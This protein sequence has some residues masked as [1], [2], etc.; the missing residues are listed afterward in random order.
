MLA[1]LLRLIS[2]NITANEKTYQRKEKY[3]KEKANK[4][5]EYRNNKSPSFMELYQTKNNKIRKKICY[6][7]KSDHIAK[8][9]NVYI[10]QRGE[11]Y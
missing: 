6:I 1:I 9:Q 3:S 8:L 7:Q 10:L 11:K 5:V 2:S 4:M